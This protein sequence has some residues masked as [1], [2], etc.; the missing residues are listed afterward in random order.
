M[1]VNACQDTRK[2]NEVRVISNAV[3]VIDYIVFKYEPAHNF[4][5]ISQNISA[6]LK[7]AASLV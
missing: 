6:F 5:T 3:D 2:K 1:S 4:S 7:K